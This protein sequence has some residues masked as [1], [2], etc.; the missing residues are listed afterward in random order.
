[1]S[2]PVLDHSEATTFEIAH[3][4]SDNLK[5]PSKKSRFSVSEP[6]KINLLKSPFSETST[7]HTLDGQIGYLLDESRAIKLAAK[8]ASSETISFHVTRAEIFL[9]S[10]C[11]MSCRYCLSKQQSMPEWDEKNLYALIEMLAERGTRHLQWT[12]GEVTTHPRLEEFISRANDLGMGN[13]ISTNGTAGTEAYADLAQAGVGHFFISLDHNNPEIFDHITRTKGK[14][15]QTTDAIRGLCKNDNRTYRVVINSVLTRE[16]VKKFME[17]NAVQLRRFLEWC[18]E[19]KADDFKFLPVSTEQFTDLFPDHETLEKFI[20]VCLNTVPERYKFFHYRLVMLEHGGHGL[21][22][23]QPHTCYHC[24]DDRAYDSLG[25]WP[26][27]IHLREGGRRLYRHND[28]TEF[29]RRQLE[30][31][32]H[33]DRTNNPICQTFCFDVY[34]ALNERVASILHPE[35]TK[36]RFGK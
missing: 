29:Q 30:S 14:F 2:Y 32:F 34:R 36:E 23:G 7:S 22:F 19:V 20:A 35:E 21:H 10:A 4:A 24:L 25:V 27:I 3:G 28:P 15:I 33:A 5:I 8:V 31:F 1:M 11:N 26:C 17:D 6:F 16:I 18:V 12:G 13:S 9:T